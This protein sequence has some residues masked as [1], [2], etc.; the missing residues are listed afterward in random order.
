M[1]P[2]HAMAWS[3][4]SSRAR[5]YDL[6]LGHT[7]FSAAELTRRLGMHAEI[8]PVGFEPTFGSPDWS[9]SK[10]HAYSYYGSFV[11]KRTWAI[12]AIARVL[13]DRLVDK[14]G[15]F[16][17]L[18]DA[19]RHT[20]ATLHVMHSDVDIFSTWRIWTALQSGAAMVS[21]PADLW[22]LIPEVHY[23][24]IPTITE[25]NVE[26]VAG[27]L[28]MLISE[29]SILKETAR[30]AWS[31]LGPAYTVDKCI[32]NHLIPASRKCL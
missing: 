14:T 18:G 17:G 20:L 30:R 22:P 21:E 10:N 11:G 4:F 7:P 13:G 16:W 12:P 1:L 25:E 31:D 26:T 3:E 29:P 19:L 23:T 9:V 27:R 5:E 24:T 2:D 28:K 8:F 32:R 15:T 6:V